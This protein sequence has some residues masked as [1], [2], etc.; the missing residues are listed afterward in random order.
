MKR[1]YKGIILTNHAIQRAKLRRVQPE[2]IVQTVHKPQSREKEADGDT[3]FTRTINGRT[4]QVIG[5]YDRDDSQW[6]I[7]TMW[8]RGEDDPSILRRVWVWFSE[9]L[10][11]G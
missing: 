8:V 4:V 7:K 1:E 2:M 10:R 9:F 5:F 11:L 3:K 6:V